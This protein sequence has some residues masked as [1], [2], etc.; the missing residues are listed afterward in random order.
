M[1]MAPISH[2]TT[3]GLSF[4]IV[5]DLR[6]SG[7]RI[8]CAEVRLFVG[9]HVGPNRGFGAAHIWAEHRR[10]MELAG[11]LREQEVAAYVAAIVRGGTLLY[12]E[13]GWQ[14]SERLLAL[15]SAVG[16][17]ILE[18]RQQRGGAIWSVVTAFSGKKAHGTRVGTVRWSP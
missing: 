1:S 18:H 14:R 17:A 7:S 4:G 11:F 2:P 12:H 3:G 9:R 8:A 15:R 5:P 10:E 6:L 16:T 13:G